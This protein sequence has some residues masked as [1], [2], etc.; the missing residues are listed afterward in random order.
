MFI[1]RKTK[2]APGENLIRTIQ[3][4][5]IAHGAALW[6]AVPDVTAV[7]RHVHVLAQPAIDDANHPDVAEV[8]TW[9]SA[10]LQLIPPRGIVCLVGN[11]AIER[12]HGNAQRVMRASQSN[13]CSDYKIRKARFAVLTRKERCIRQITGRNRER[14][15][16]RYRIQWARTTWRTTVAS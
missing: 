2:T 5:S 8:C 16:N 3:Q 13:L 11:P 1:D 7:C 14:C 15:W 9:T 10:A 6:I 4:H 12:N